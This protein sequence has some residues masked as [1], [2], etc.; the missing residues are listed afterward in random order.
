MLAAN[1]A[2]PNP[3]FVPVTVQTPAHAGMTFVLLCSIGAARIA[4]SIACSSIFGGGAAL[5]Q[6][7]PVPMVIPNLAGKKHDQK[8]RPKMLITYCSLTPYYNGNQ[9]ADPGSGTN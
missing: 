7:G 8:R 1:G 6:L 2:V 4:A 5:S 3:I 9:E